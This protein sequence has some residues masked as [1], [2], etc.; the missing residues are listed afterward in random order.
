MVNVNVLLLRLAARSGLQ[1]ACI[2]T[3]ADITTQLS[4]ERRKISITKHTPENP[5]YDPVRTMRWAAVGLTLHG[6][7]FFLSFRK[8]DCLLGGATS[9]TNAA[10]KTVI[11]QL[12]VF[13]PYLVALFAC[14][15][16]MEG[17]NDMYK[18]RTNVKHR[19]PEAFMGGCVYWPIAN[20]INF[21]FVSTGARIPYLAAVGG[22]WNAYL[23]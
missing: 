23:S 12:L 4:L 11:A 22:L 5:N 2:M 9:A 21:S 15:G 6:P 18:I 7:Y 13:P 20:F 10:K 14:M 16:V 3:V 8:L 1:S 19:V 17:K